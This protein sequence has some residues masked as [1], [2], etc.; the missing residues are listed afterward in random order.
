[1]VFLLSIA[2]VR[3][4]SGV[5]PRPQSPESCSGESRG[6]V[7]TG[8]TRVWFTCQQETTL[9]ERLSVVLTSLRLCVFSGERGRQGEGELGSSGVDSGSRS[10]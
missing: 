4:H 5:S 6:A 1:M 9:P 7:F 8:E 2:D 3:K 10:V